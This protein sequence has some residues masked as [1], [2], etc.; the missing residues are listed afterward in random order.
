LRDPKTGKDINN[1]WNAQQLCRF[2]P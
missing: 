1:P 2:Y